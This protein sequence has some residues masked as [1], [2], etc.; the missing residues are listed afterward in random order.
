GKAKALIGE[1]AGGNA[2]ER[3][4]LSHDLASVGIHLL[5]YALDHRVRLGMDGGSVQWIFT[6]RYT[7]ETGS[8]F[9]CLVAEAWHFHQSFPIGKGSVTVAPGHN[10]LCQRCIQARYA[11]QQG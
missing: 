11:G 6:I 7:Q 5:K 1:L 4:R 2:F 8:L 10:I 9:K 3:A